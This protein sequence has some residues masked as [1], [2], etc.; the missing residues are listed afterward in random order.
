M[1]L[2][3]SL[4]PAAAVTLSVT[5]CGQPGSDMAMNDATLVNDEG[6]FS[7]ESPLPFNYPQ[8]DQLDDSLYR[9]AFER[10]MSEHL[11]EVDAIANAPDRPTIENT[12]VELERSGRVL[13][14]VQRVF[15]NLVSADTNDA[16]EEIR[17]E[18][19]PRLA[20]HSDAILLN[21]TLFSRVKALVDV[22]ESLDVDDESRRLIEE[23]YADFVRAGAQLSDTDKPHL[24]D[25]NA[26]LAT[27]QTT[28]SQ[29]VLNEVNRSAV[30]VDERAELAGLSESE[31][32]A[33]AEMATAKAL[34]MTVWCP[35]SRSVESNCGIPRG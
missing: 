35:D 4:L 31:I 27:L 12:L 22:R 3:R 30:A 2:C 10:G 7:S 16:L 13:E 5:A 33:A 23:Y 21:N 32:T 6:L 26:E 11:A 18:M 25:I 24:R 8:F 15:F 9:P 19:A 29:N 17:S 14:R 34:F 1:R 20:A 28:F